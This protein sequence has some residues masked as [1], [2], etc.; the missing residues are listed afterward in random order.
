M[1]AR[2]PILD[3]PWVQNFLVLVA[4]VISVYSLAPPISPVL[5][6]AR[7]IS[8]LRSS[9]TSPLAVDATPLPPDA[10][11]KPR[12]H[13][14]RAK[15]LFMT[16]Y[17]AGGPRFDSLVGL[18]QRTELN[19]AVIDVKDER[20]EISWVPKSPQA[21]M[22]GAGFP[23]MLNPARTIRRLHRRGIY[24]IGRIVTFQDPILAEVRPDLA[25]QDTHGGIWH[26]RR[27]MAWLDPYSTE[28][29]DYNIALAIEAVSLGF[30]EIQ[31]DYVRFPT[32]GD[33]TRMWSR[34]KDERLPDRVIADFLAR[35]GAQIVPRG[36]Y[37]SSDLFGLTALVSDDLGIGQKLELIAQQVDYISLML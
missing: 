14:V 4:L 31:F 27:G 16:G 20:G 34:F 30:D 15:G 2:R 36:A 26:T 21:R 7:S 37:I 13:A 17:T 12:R 32:D 28:A 5:S 6:Q 10:K 1:R 24:V 3:R 18:V 9:K 29:Q 33:T 22:A 19:S 8:F 35:A 25:I 11:P 23:K